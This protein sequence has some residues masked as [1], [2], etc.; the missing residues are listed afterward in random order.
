[1]TELDDFFRS[2]RAAPD[3]AL[4]RLVLADWLDEHE[5]PDWAAFIRGQCEAARLLAEPALVGE[6]M[7]PETR[8]AA[9]LDRL[10]QGHLTA[11]PDNWWRWAGFPARPKH[12]YRVLYHRGF[13][14]SIDCN[15]QGWE[16]EGRRG[17]KA[18]RGLGLSV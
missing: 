12:I 9:V 8:R 7:P 11:H 5:E 15:R 18:N 6:F 14:Q 17:Y 3:D 4:P 13:P 10:A 1:M 16:G 2:I